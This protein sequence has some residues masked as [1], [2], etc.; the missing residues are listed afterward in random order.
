MK[1]S[2]VERGR[3]GALMLRQQFFKVTTVHLTECLV[4]TGS[5][6]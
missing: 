3:Q 6:R 4:M 5:R 1:E 2:K